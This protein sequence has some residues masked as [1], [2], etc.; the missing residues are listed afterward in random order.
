MNQAHNT[1]L[2]ALFRWVFTLLLT[3]TALLVHA[4]TYTFTGSFAWNNASNWTPAGVPPNPLPS[5]AEVVI[6]GN[7]FLDVPRTISPGAKLTINPGAQFLQ[8]SALTIEGAAENK[9]QYTQLADL[10]LTGSFANQTPGGRYQQIGGVAA[11]AGDLVNQATMNITAGTMT[12]QAGGSITNDSLLNLLGALQMYHQM[13]NNGLIS[14][15]GTFQN[16]DSPGDLLVNNGSFSINGTLNNAGVDY[17]INAGSVT[18]SGRIVGNFRNDA[19]GMLSPGETVGGLTI[20]GN[21][22]NQGDLNID[23][24]TPTFSDELIV[25]G[26]ALL[27]GALNINLLATPSAGNTFSIVRGIFSGNFGGPPTLPD[28]SDWTID[29]ASPDYRLIYNGSALPIKLLAFQGRRVGAAIEINWRTASEQ[30][31]AFMEILRSA[32]GVAFE[33]LVRIDGRGDAHIPRDYRFL[34]ERP[35]SGINYYRLRQTDYDGT[36]ALFPVIAVRYETMDLQISAGRDRLHLTL[37]QA[38]RTRGEAR[39]FDYQ[40]RLLAQAVFPAGVTECELPAGHLPAGAYIVVLRIAQ[41]AWTASF[42]K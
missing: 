40:G 21:F 3:Q 30:D 9:G 35:L 38:S 6:N 31:N 8:F 16:G 1:L 25:T 11:I 5:G 39:I 4:Q 22:E 12:I 34:D 37:S 2:S 26:T 7:C 29:D 15:L 23:L 20:Q 19:G 27:N 10:T 33:P 42:F 36:V 32:D 17:F 28:P 24:G 18:G 41:E 14:I 13:T